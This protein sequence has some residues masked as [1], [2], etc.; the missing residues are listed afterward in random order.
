MSGPVFNA[1]NNPPFSYKQQQ[2][3]QVFYI[4]PSP[5]Q[6]FIA[7]G[8]IMGATNILLFNIYLIFPLLPQ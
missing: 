1:I 5:R 3:G 4:Y 8:L 7:E 2:N 6:Q